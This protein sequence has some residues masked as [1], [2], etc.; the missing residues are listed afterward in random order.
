[1]NGVSLNQLLKGFRDELESDVF[2]HGL[3]M[4]SRKIRPGDLFI[5]YPGQQVDGR[6]YIGEA[7]E[8][9]AVAVLYESNHYEL[10]I[11]N[12]IPLIAFSNLQHH[13]GHIAARFYGDPSKTIKV[14]GVTGTNGKTS[15]THFI[16]QSL[17][18]QKIPCGI[19]G[20]L[21]YGFIGNLNKT[22][23]TTPDPIQLQQVL[24][25]LR[26]QGAK[27]IAMEVSSHALDQYRVQGVHFTIAVFTQLSRDHLDYHHNMENY[28]RTKALLFQQS[29]LRY[30]VINC[31]D[32]LG[33]RIIET[34]YS[35]LTLIGYSAD[36]IEDTRIACV[37]A[38]HI[39]TLTHGFSVDVQT[40]WG[41]GTFTIS[42]LG[43]FN[44]SNLLSV[45]SVLCLCEVSFEKA[46]MELSKLNI[47]PGR[48]Q[49]VN[50]QNRP[51]VIVD[52]AHTPDALEKSL[53]A[54]REHCKG[55]LICVFGCGGD[56]DQGKR[57]Q[58]AAVAERLTNQI[59]L[60]NDNPRNQHPLAIIRD[61]QVGF[62]NR[63]SI[64]VETDRAKAIKCAVQ[65]ATI[66]DIVF[67]AGKG[68]ETMQVIGT[69]VLPFNDVE[70]AK[71]ALNS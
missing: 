10:S 8:K 28:A 12:I 39:K 52:Y 68:H 24:A 21:G 35:K 13:I 54:L 58:M 7:I 69:D 19:V 22:D 64:I 62:K 65:K 56:R 51:R 9:Q 41:K 18:S 25:Q 49:V 36:G 4:D 38:T 53:I 57:P 66:N 16:A 44:I 37:R 15:C 1:M 55:R 71:K 60:T 17:Q 40:S 14:I 23:Y 32:V 29:D 45:L 63:H 42:L 34:N 61:I 2:I 59:I 70:E 50:I 27:V 46:L 67:I 6:R 30:G 31:D 48:M 33:R 43:R 47:V 26:K 5:A 3:Q 11:K 20:T